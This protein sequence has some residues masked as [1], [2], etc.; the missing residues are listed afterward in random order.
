M[1]KKLIRFFL[2]EEDYITSVVTEPGVTTKIDGSWVKNHDEHIDD[3]D[4]F[5][6]SFTSH[7]LEKTTNMHELKASKIKVLKEIGSTQ[8][9]KLKGIGIISH[10]EHELI[11]TES[12]YIVK[13][14]Q[15]EFNPISR[16]IEN[17]YD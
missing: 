5:T 6:S 11:K 10:G 2:P 17:A 13:Y 7:C 14:V 8:V 1:F 12:H 3:L 16:I 4:N 9:L 15:Q